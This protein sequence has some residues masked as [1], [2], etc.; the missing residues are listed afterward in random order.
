MQEEVIVEVLVARERGV[1][2]QECRLSMGASVARTELQDA[3][4]LSRTFPEAVR[5]TVV[6]VMLSEPPAGARRLR[7]W[8]RADTL[9]TLA[10]K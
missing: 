5:A 1:E 2:A 8:V 7:R 6:E 3:M 9:E 10:L 4:A